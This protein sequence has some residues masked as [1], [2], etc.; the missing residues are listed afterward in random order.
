MCVL[1]YSFWGI[2]MLIVNTLFLLDNY[3]VFVAM[4]LQIE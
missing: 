4:W 1:P 2:F 3:I